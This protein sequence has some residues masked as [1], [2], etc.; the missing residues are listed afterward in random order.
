MTAVADDIDAPG[1]VSYIPVRN[2]WLLMLYAS[3]MYRYL[4]YRS[5]SAEESPDQIPDLAAEILCHHYRCRSELICLC[6]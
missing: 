3:D 5:I 2:I 4:G 1:F 6:Y